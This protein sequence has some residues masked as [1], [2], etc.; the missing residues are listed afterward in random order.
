MSDAMAPN[1]SDRPAAGRCSLRTP[2]L[3]IGYA[4][5]VPDEGLRSID[6]PEPLTRLEFAALIRATLSHKGRGEGGAAL[7]MPH[8]GSA[9]EYFTWLK[10]KLDSMEAM[11]SS[12]VS[13]FFKNASYDDRSAATTRSR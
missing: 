8:T 4:K 13:L 11:P 2:M 10:A 3:C 9:I 5:S 6:V 12:R 7:L 1:D